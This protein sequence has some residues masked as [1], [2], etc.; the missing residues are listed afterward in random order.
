V[1][2]SCN[3]NNTDGLT[4]KAQRSNKAADCGEQIMMHCNHFTMLFCC[5]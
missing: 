2:R 1:A 5:R 4:T 3:A